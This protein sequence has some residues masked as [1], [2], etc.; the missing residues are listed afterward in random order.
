VVV[1]GERD[2]MRPDAPILVT[3]MPRSGTT[4]IARVLAS[5]PGT[6]LAGREP[7]NPRPRQYALGGTL[8]SWARLEAP[9][10][11]QAF[12]LRLAYRGINPW[13]FS[14]YG[15]RQ[16]AAPWPGTRIIVKDPF[17]ALS[18]PAVTATTGA[19]ALVTYRHPGAMLVSFRRVGWRPDLAEIRP[20]VRRPDLLAAAGPDPG[21]EPA[22]AAGADGASG[23]DVRAMAAF[24][25]ALYD[26]ILADLDRVPGALL[27]AHEDLAGGG[28]A[29]LRTLY[30]ALDL[31]WSE[32]AG[33]PFAAPVSAGPAGPTGTALHN[34]DRAPAQVAAAWMSALTPDELS[35][36]N[37][38][39]VDVQQELAGRRLRLS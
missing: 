26:Q 39:T 1:G 4:W 11:R 15:R 23:A 24:W 19:R 17:A 12:D 3:G 7:M 13:V 28:E 38:L 9:T 2:R 33:R 6:A 18:L 36:I 32:E 35:E 27:I 21:R 31:G 29:A 8:E 22:G 37:A 20:L 34:F 5:A 14:R 30:A 16:W 10:R 25:A